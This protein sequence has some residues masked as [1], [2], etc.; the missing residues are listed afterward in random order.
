MRANDD[1]DRFE[2]WRKAEAAY[3]AEFALRQAD[4]YHIRCRDCGVF[5]SKRRWVKKDSY[6]ALKHQQRPL[7]A[8]CWDEY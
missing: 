8:K 5:V 6:D 1:E 3:E 7:C 4:D 2:S